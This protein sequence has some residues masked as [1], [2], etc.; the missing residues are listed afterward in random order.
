MNRGMA[1]PLSRGM[2]RSLLIGQ[3]SGAP[4]PPEF[5]GPLDDQIAQLFSA[6]STRRLLSS[7]SGPLVQVRRSSDNALADI[8][9]DAYGELDSAALLAHCGAGS[10]Y[11]RTFYDQTG[12]TRH[13][14]SSAN[15]NQPTIVNTGVV[16]EIVAGRAGA[17]FV[18]DA[19]GRKWAQSVAPGARTTLFT[20]CKTSRLLGNMMYD[21]GAWAIG[22]WSSTQP[23][24]STSFS[25][26]NDI[27]VNNLSIANDKAL[28][29]VALATG[30]P[31]LMSTDA[32]TSP[33]V[34]TGFGVYPAGD[35]ATEGGDGYWVDFILYAANVSARRAAITTAL[36][37][38]G[39]IY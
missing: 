8:S 29:A 14:V 25:G 38:G 17:L 15:G 27:Y 4:P 11:I 5:V 1:F 2:A 34:N 16:Q 21:T 31:R 23:G 37:D 7:Y 33:F 26:V 32:D 10:G 20:T 3:T 24:N 39:W 13:G 19:T 30:T 18:G 36:N 6:Y 12:N 22:I 9:G 35:P 28:L